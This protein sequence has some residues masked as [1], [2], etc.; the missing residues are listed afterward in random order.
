VN[1]PNVVTV[2]DVGKVKDPVTGEIVDCVI[3]EMIRGRQMSEVWNQ[4]QINECLGLCKQIIAGIGAMHAEGVCHHDL[5]AGNV[6][7]CNSS[8]KIIDIQYTESA[9]L[10]KIHLA[11]KFRLIEEDCNATARLC[12]NMIWKTNRELLTPEIDDRLTRVR[13]LEELRQVLSEIGLP[14]AQSVVTTPEVSDLLKDL[15]PIDKRVLQLAGD[16]VLA[17]DRLVGAISVAIIVEGIGDYNMVARS[18][19]FLNE[20]R[21]L[22][23]FDQ[24]HPR[25]VM[26]STY[27]FDRYLQTFRKE[28]SLEQRKICAA[29]VRLER[30]R[31]VD[32]M[33]LT[34]VP[35]PIVEHVIMVLTR[36]GL[37]ESTRYNSETQIHTISEKL[38]RQFKD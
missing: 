31:D 18:I 28:Y 17:Q 3:M 5:H 33:A 30:T 8:L 7:V 29:I 10:S 12:R 15:S 23:E 6:I 22:K 14:D 37:V 4:I 36:E 24:S 19:Q 38:R 25:F 2:Y 21:Y 20:L 35:R 26:L 32:I 1:H 11:S 27:G 34:E 13:S 16:H 9:R